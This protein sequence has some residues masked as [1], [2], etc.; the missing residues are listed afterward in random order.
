MSLKVY[1]GEIPLCDGHLSMFQFFFAS[2]HF[3]FD[4]SS[5]GPIITFCG[6][7]I[8][9]SPSAFVLT[10][11]LGPCIF[12][13]ASV[14]VIKR[15]KIC[16]KKRNR[17][18]LKTKTQHARI[19][20]CAKRAGTTE[21]DPQPK[22]KE[23]RRAKRR[24]K[25]T[26]TLFHA[27]TF[28]RRCIF[29]RFSRKFGGCFWLILEYT[30]HCSIHCEWGD[31]KRLDTVARWLFEVW[32]PT[33]Y[34]A[35]ISLF[36]CRKWIYFLVCVRV[37][38]NVWLVLEWTLCMS[39]ILSVSIRCKRAPKHTICALQSYWTLIIRQLIHLLHSAGLHDWYL[40]FHDMCSFWFSS[41][42]ISRSVLNVEMN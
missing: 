31:D 13:S 9:V 7:A 21:S 2:M 5:N 23:E 12:I 22:K 3:Y 10:Q 19:A 15:G 34:T 33:F 30:N 18:V 41:S 8:I 20:W 26:K 42:F 14:F 27:E 1:V 38:A 16:I 36:A 11:L 39:M 4:S 32:S 28:V 25:Q 35:S 6:F 37:R 24:L 17:M 40:Y 29:V